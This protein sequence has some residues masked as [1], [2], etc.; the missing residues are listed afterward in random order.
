MSPDYAPFANV[1]RFNSPVY[2]HWEQQDI[3]NHVKWFADMGW[4]I[5]AIDPSLG[6]GG[7]QRDMSFCLVRLLPDIQ[8]CL[9]P[10][11][12]DPAGTVIYVDYLYKGSNK[13]VIECFMECYRRWGKQ[14]THV[15]FHRETHPDRE[16]VMYP[17]RYSL[18]FVKS[19][20]KP[21]VEQCK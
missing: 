21:E 12:G 9:Q 3:V 1:L 16:Y 15:G 4:L 8:S 11:Y 18:K 14:V 20:V 19:L 17:A 2:R 13:G 5:A 6:P 7:V 10:Y